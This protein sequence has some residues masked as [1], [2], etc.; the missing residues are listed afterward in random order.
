MTVIIPPCK[1][2]RKLCLWE[3]ILFSRCPSVHPSVRPYRFV[4][5]ISLRVING[6]SS[7]LAYLFIS[8]GPILIIKMYGAIFMR[9]ISLCNS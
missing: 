3:G 7:N 2:S 8:K 9:V 4:S 1:L 5:L 6:I